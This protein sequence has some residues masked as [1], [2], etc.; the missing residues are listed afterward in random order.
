[1][2]TNICSWLKKKKI[3]Q[4]DIT[5]VSIYKPDMHP[6]ATHIQKFI[7]EAILHCSSA[8]FVLKLAY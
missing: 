7:K 6:P 5:L 2:K 1:M 8:N 3:Q 4:L